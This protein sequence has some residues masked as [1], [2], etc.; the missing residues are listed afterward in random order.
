M[1]RHH[2]SEVL[3]LQAYKNIYEFRVGAVCERLQARTSNNILSIALDKGFSSKSAFNM[4]FKKITGLTPSQY[5]KTHDL[6]E[7]P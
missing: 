2:V 1:S 3:N 6:K 5:R 4:V 7:T